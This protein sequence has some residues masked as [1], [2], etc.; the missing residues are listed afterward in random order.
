MKS[1]YFILLAAMAFAAG[2]CTGEKKK[3]Q[4]PVDSGR[5]RWTVQQA[6]DWYQ[7][8][9]WLVGCNFLPSTASNQLEMWQASSFDTATINREL[10]WAAGL[11]MNTVRVY[12]HDLLYEQDSSGFYQRV[13]TFL[14]IASRHKIK[15][16]LVLFDSVWDPFPKPGEQRVPKPHVHNAGWVQSPGKEALLDSTRHPRLQ[17]YVR[18]TVG[19]FANDTRILA[20]DVW[21]EPENP[22]KSAYGDVEIPDKATVVLPLLETTFHTARSVNPVQP[23]T[24]GV[25]RDDWSE[26]SKLTPINRLML[27]ESD[28][29]SFHSYDSPEEFEKRVKWLQ[30]LGR[31]LICT[32]YMARGN[33]ST[34]EG[35]L[36]IAKAHRVAAINWGL[37]DGKSQTIYPWD[38]WKK[39]YTGEP[40]TWFH[41]IFRRDGTPYKE[42]EVVF[43]KKIIS[44][45]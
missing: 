1:T 42:S 32:E 16:V 43:I 8:Q 13:D 26:E 33:N 36:P 18:G 14:E 3:E 38:S 34:F 15:P 21:N 22:N 29:I 19:H 37:V 5:D 10:G 40:E 24:A 2:A 41:D 20:W 6:N 44:E 30:P 31:P 27:D 12:L 25:W 7:S 45:K 39:T 23:L 35:I 28:V 4:P 9:P 17:N 11:G